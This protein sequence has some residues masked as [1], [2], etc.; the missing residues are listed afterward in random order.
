MSAVRAHSPDGVDLPTLSRAPRTAHA[1]P[2][3]GVALAAWLHLRGQSSLGLLA[4]EYWGVLAT[5][6]PWPIEERLILSIGNLSEWSWHTLTSRCAFTGIE[7]RLPYAVALI[8]ATAMAAFGNRRRRSLRERL[9]MTAFLL[10]TP[11]PL[12]YGHW[13]RHYGLLILGA[14]ATWVWRDR[15]RFCAPR[16]GAQA[17]A[18]GASPFGM[19]VFLAGLW[20]AW[21]QQRP[22]R[23]RGLLL[24]AALLSLVFA[25]QAWILTR[26]TVVITDAYGYSLGGRQGWFTTESLAQL[27]GWRLHGWQA[28]G[29]WLLLGLGLRGLWRAR[30]DLG[31]TAGVAL[32]GYA[33]GWIIFQP[34][35]FSRYLL[36][37]AMLWPLLLDRG[38]PRGRMTGR[39]A[40]AALLLAWLP[41]TLNIARWTPD[42]FAN[43][44]LRLPE[45]VLEPDIRT[46]D[47]LVTDLSILVEP[48]FLYT[49]RRVPVDAVI[50]NPRPYGLD[51][52]RYP[53]LI[54]RLDR[55][56]EA[57]WS[58]LQTH[59]R[60]TDFP[61][62]RLL[63]RLQTGQTL[64]AFGAAS[65]P[66][67]VCPEICPE[68]LRPARQPHWIRS[69]KDLTAWCR[70]PGPALVRVDRPEQVD[71]LRIPLTPGGRA[72]L[73]ELCQPVPV[74]EAGP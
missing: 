17:L 56:A 45:Q 68:G 14:V 25:I 42:V 16:L 59:E 64:V 24:E 3:I 32:V 36:P 30:R 15:A 53:W 27:L 7:A 33:L 39:M 21:R 29:W 55:L 40:L 65:L 12:A 5:C 69:A 54:D 1:L 38:W 10:G 70:S 4:N 43:L 60:H 63:E 46:A 26:Y 35:L 51:M 44:E 57:P 47:A 74:P 2:A 8:A 18:A 73:P 67:Q 6:L 50:V 20:G 13:G 41:T 11:Y 58:R 66:P 19:P 52:P 72:A 9:L 34:P 23:S 31:R 28:L 22:T 62:E 48:P 37:L 71:W 61:R 49:V